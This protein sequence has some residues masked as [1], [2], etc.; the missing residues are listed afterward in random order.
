MSG[1]L[2]FNSMGLHFASY[3]KP[4]FSSFIFVLGLV[5]FLLPS[6]R[7]LRMKLMNIFGGTVGILTLISVYFLTKIMTRHRLA[8]K[9]MI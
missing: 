5:G 6:M 7:K 2:T 3:E 4:Y 8:K 9:K 1:G